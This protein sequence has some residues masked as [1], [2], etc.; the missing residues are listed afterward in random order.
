MLGNGACEL[1]LRKILATYLPAVG[2]LLQLVALAQPAYLVAGLAVQAVAAIAAVLL[3][4]TGVARA[5]PLT[6]LPLLGCCPTGV[7]GLRLDTWEKAPAV[8]LALDVLVQG[9]HRAHGFAPQ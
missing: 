2:F 6:F 3:A 1:L 8:V 5:T 9:R 7:L 4:Q